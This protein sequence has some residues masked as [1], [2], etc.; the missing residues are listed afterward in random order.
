M[1]VLR[2]VHRLHCKASYVRS[3]DDDYGFVRTPDISYAARFTSVLE[4]LKFV[5]RYKPRH[6]CGE[7]DIVRI[8]E[9]A[10]PRYVEDGVLE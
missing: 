8:R 3:T 2:S 1:Y 5:S 7:Y 4:L 10:N 6:P 9:V